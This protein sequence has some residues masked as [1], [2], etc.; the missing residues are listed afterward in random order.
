MRITF[1]GRSTAAP[2]GDEPRQCAATT[3]FNV[4]FTMG[5]P[6]RTMIGHPRADSDNS[7]YSRIREYPKS[8]NNTFVCHR[9]ASIV[10]RRP[11]VPPLPRRRG[12]PFTPT[13]LPDVPTGW[14]ARRMSHGRGLHPT[15]NVWLPVSLATARLRGNPQVRRVTRPI[16]AKFQGTRCARP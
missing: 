12:S 3:T 14:G 7:V 8:K 13:G 6:L 5:Y 1:C 16:S 2:R 10:D 11:D 4:F 15:T 9:L